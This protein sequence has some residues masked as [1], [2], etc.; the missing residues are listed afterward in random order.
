MDKL[1]FQNKNTGDVLN[2]SEWNALVSKVD[3]IADKVDPECLQVEI[4]ASLNSPEDVANIKVVAKNTSLENS[5]TCYTLV[6]ETTGQNTEETEILLSPNSSKTIAQCSLYDIIK[7]VIY[8]KSN[9]QGPWAVG[10]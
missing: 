6:D 8:M 4:D 7:L 3:E 5:C 10:L 2:A 1:N 9:K